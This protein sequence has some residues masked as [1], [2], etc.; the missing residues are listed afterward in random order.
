MRK[1]ILW[2]ASVTERYCARPQTARA[3]ISNPVSRGQCHLN[4]LN[5]H[6]QE[7]L[8]AQFSLYV[9]KGGLKP[10]SF[11]FLKRLHWLPIEFRFHFKICAITFRTLKDNQ[12]VYLAD[13][14]VQPKRSKYLRSTNSNRSV[15]PHIRTN[16]KQ[17]TAFS[18]SGPALWNALPVPVWN[19]ETILT[20]R[21]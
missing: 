5:H 3:R 9:H 4:H 18:I 17:T 7:V 1:S 21:K 12:P 15:V 16:N 8:L 13:L 19:A 20:F 10:D 14:L 2:G 11:Y 6:P